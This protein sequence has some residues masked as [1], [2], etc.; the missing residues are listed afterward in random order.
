MLI[1][2]LL[3]VFDV[4]K[5]YILIRFKNNMNASDRLSALFNES[6]SILIG[7]THM[8]VIEC[9]FRQIFDRIRESNPD[10][11]K[12]VIA[13]STDFDADDLSISNE[14]KTVIREEVEV[15]GRQGV[16]GWMGFV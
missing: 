14:F 7:D 11:F 1:E 6:V 2:K 13:I 10:A 9:F 8:Y 15:G 16:V 3:R 5:I 12:K 4:R